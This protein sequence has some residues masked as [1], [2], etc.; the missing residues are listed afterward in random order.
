MYRRKALFLCRAIVLG[1]LA[2]CLAFPRLPAQAQP[3]DSLAPGCW[4]VVPTPV[5]NGQ[6][7]Y[8]SSLATGDDQA[9]WALGNMAGP[10]APASTIVRWDGSEWRSP[11]STVFTTTYSI[12]AF[13]AFSPNEVWLIGS[14]PA[15]PT[16]GTQTNRLTARWDGTQWR[17]VPNP[18][19]GLDQTYFTDI[20]GNSP[21]DLW[22]VG[23]S[24][25]GP[26]NAQQT[27]VTL[28]WDGRRWTQHGVPGLD[29]VV[30]MDKVLA[31]APNDV[32]AVGTHILHWD[33][34]TW[35]SVRVDPTTDYRDV[36]STPGGDAWAVGDRNDQPTGARWD[37]QNWSVT[38]MPN[39]GRY[40]RLNAVAPLADDDIWAA[41]AYEY[42]ENALIL[43]WNGTTWNPIPNPVPGFTSEITGMAASNG[44]I[45][46]VGWRTMSAP[47]PGAFTGP[48]EPL[49]MRYTPTPCP[50]ALLET[51]LN[52]PVPLP[53]AGGVTFP[54][55]G[56]TVTGTFLNYWLA[57]GGLAQQGYP[58][59][60]VIGETSD[61]DGKVYTAQYFERA[62]FEYHPE[63]RGTPYEVLLAHLGTFRYRQKYP[64]GAPNQRP[65]TDPGTITF[66]ETGKRLGG[67]F[68]Q[69]WQSHGGLMQQGFPISDEFTEVSP[70]DGRPYTVQYFER[71]VFEWHPENLGTP[72]NVL[73]SHLGRFRYRERYI[74]KSA[75]GPAP[76]QIAG[77]VMP[78]SLR[79]GGHHLVWQDMRQGGYGS[80]TVYAYDAVQN[81][82]M[83]IS[84]SMTEHGLPL[85]TNGVI[86]LWSPRNIDQRYISGYEFATGGRPRVDPPATNSSPDFRRSDIAFA[87]RTLYYT[88]NWPGHTG[89][90]MLDIR[91]QVERKLYD[92][93]PMPGSLR[94]SDA[95][96]LVLWTEER[97]V[98]NQAERL[99]RV[100]R[101]D[102][103]ATQT[104]HRGY[105]AYSGY[106]ASYTPSEGHK[107][108]YSFYS[109]IADQ[110]I[111]VEE[112]R[113]GSGKAIH[114]GSA[115]SS[116]TIKGDRVAW[117]LWPGGAGETGGWRIELYDTRNVS[118]TTVVQ[119]FP[120]MP[121][122]LTL[123]ENDKVAFTAD[124]D[125]GTPGEELYLLD[126]DA[127]P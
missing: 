85:V 9:M 43:H 31:V 94:A 12:T 13:K 35:S 114:S 97:T 76:R 33:G 84:T 127:R 95:E 119:G 121:H 115:T 55:T 54:E 2:L 53:G 104:L 102:T 109:R 69:Y 5:V 81:R 17:V 58:I 47:G 24:Y 14:Y 57:R 37:G 51:P 41:G 86:A 21:G 100:Y 11:R 117:V 116:P 45:W 39:P 7:L 68:L 48:R 26:H 1:A 44:E 56:N 30:R 22:V 75:Q 62:V 101:E 107:V 120:A 23:T 99:L 126:L 63:N 113:S 16:P 15:A 59:S 8:I 71:A 66:P 42:K 60:G 32:W 34:R 49:L 96:G 61:T 83:P 36:V 38:S 10:G 6:P 88:D 29:N 20:D 124:V 87:G 89:L 3:A 105:G 90:F 122:D 111:F 93:L 82:E 112:V 25:G 106:A 40:G 92:G 78:S 110:N 79:G 108:V 91:V 67:A 64:G 27:G 73:L 98:G 70:L 103:G 50:G 52:P 118:L 72:N 4:R 125:L 65:N 80:Q 46:A 74:D 28:H 19:T 123:L 77:S 18:M